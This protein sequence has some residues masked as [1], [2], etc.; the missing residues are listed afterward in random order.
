MHFDLLQV[1]EG[2][3]P[4]ALVWMPWKQEQPNP[5]EGKRR[6]KPGHFSSQS[7][8]WHWVVWGDWEITHKTQESRGKCEKVCSQ[9]VSSE[10]LWLPNTLPDFLQGFICWRQLPFKLC[11]LKQDPFFLHCCYCSKNGAR[12][13]QAWFG[14]LLFFFFFVCVVGRDLCAGVWIKFFLKNV[15]FQ[16][17]FQ[18]IWSLNRCM[19][20]VKPCWFSLLPKTVFSRSTLLSLPWT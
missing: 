1:E 6:K 5:R 10:V 3:I 19:C 15:Y 18:K 16:E 20:R 8:L 13:N 17:M 14:V 12:G 2:N 4:L 11:G 9:L 7:S